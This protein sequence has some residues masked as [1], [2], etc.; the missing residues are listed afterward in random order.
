MP[1]FALVFALLGVTIGATAADLR[2]KLGDPLLVEDLTDISRVGDYLRADDASAVLRVTEREGVVFAVEVARERTEGSL[3]AGDSYG[4][5]LGMPRATVLAKRGKPALT[6][7]N[8]LLYPEDPGEDASTIYRFDDDTL[9]SIKLVGSGSTA[10]GNPAL[11]KLTDPSGESY[12]TAILDLSPS[13]QT[14]DHFHEQYLTVHGCDLSGRHST[15]ERRDGRTYVIASG[16]CK[17]KL[18][19]FYFDVTRARS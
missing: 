10:A 1:I 7:A 17:D 12:A 9:E 15:V 19:V 3:G 8:T 2:A 14:S 13:P 18:R 5:L 6:T 11:P 4:I 16:V